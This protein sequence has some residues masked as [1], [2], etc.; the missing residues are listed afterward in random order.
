M[1]IT[2]RQGE[3]RRTQIVQFVADYWIAEHIA[4]SVADVTRGCGFATK[5][6]AKYH[7]DL[8]VEAGVLARK[9]GVPRSLRVVQQ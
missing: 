3:D 6:A 7:L 2:S 5:S 4:P 1:S 9:A 8:L